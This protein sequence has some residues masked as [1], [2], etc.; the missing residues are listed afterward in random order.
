VIWHS[1]LTQLIWVGPFSSLFF[2][3][4]ILTRPSPFGLRNPTQAPVVWPKNLHSFSLT[5]SRPNHQPGEDSD[6]LG[7]SGVFFPKTHSWEIRF[8]ECLM[9]SSVFHR[10]EDRS[11]GFHQD[12]KRCK[13]IE[14]FASRDHPLHPFHLR[15]GRICPPPDVWLGP[16]VHWLH[17]VDSEWN[18]FVSSASEVRKHGLVAKKGLAA[19]C[20]SL[21][22]TA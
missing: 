19:I 8:L 14:P 16:K 7:S 21:I 13:H 3:L 20:S 6:F 22:A 17:S 12:L 2:F 5:G 4:K 10:S 11:R 1:P 15:A 18:L 9:V